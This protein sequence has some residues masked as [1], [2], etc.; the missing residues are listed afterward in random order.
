MKLLAF[1]ASNSLKSIN[2]QL[3]TYAVS[4]V[5]ADE[6]EILDLNDYEL[7]L[8]SQDR[9]DAI[10]NPPLAQQFLDKIGSCD[11]LII[12]FAEHN[13]SYSVAY[14]NIF[15]WASRINMKV[16]QNK[17]M[18]LMATSPG[19]RGGQS[20]LET[21]VK[22]APFFKGDVKGQFSLPFFAEN[23]DTQKGCISNKE[24]DE[25]LKA[26]LKKLM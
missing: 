11:A 6:V 23:F 15:D 22:T 8:Y 3:V 14:K 10:G 17:P 7:P 26:V 9:N 4:L 12:S 2:K 1:A 19:G 24:K 18:I 13:L 20:V 16:F 5:S 21:A 25:E